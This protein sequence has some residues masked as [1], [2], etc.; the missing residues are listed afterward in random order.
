MRIQWFI[1]DSTRDWMKERGEFLSKC[2]KCSTNRIVAWA[3]VDELVNRISGGIVFSK[4]LVSPVIVG[5]GKG[6]ESCS[7]VGHGDLTTIDVIERPKRDE[8]RDII[9]TM[10]VNHCS[11]IRKG[12]HGST[13]KMAIDDIVVIY[14]CHAIRD[15]CNGMIITKVVAKACLAFD[16]EHLTKG[17][18]EQYLII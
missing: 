5:M 4:W 9:E 18:S 12:V 3:V 11:V 14:V 8:E 6:E 17:T 13:S 15:V 2:K 10:I 1:G 16:E 7:D